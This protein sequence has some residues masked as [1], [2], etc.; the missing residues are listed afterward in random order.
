MVV[1]NSQLIYVFT[2]LK[3]VLYGP[4]I[5]AL[6]VT[7]TQFG[8]LL[9]FVGFITVFG[10]ATIG[11]LQDRFAIRKVLAVN[12]LMYGGWAMVMT[13]W[14][15]CPYILKC[16]F[17]I[18]FGFNGDA[19]Y[20]ATVLKSIRI[21][22]KEDKQATAFGMMESIRALIGF[23][24]SSAVVAIYTFLGSTLFGMRV[25]MGITSTFTIISGLTIWF[26]IPELK[27]TE[28]DRKLREEEKKAGKT[29]N[30]FGGFIKALKMPGVW[31]TGGAAMCVYA[32]FCAVNTYF[33]PYMQN[34]YLLPVALL[35]VFGIV[36]GYLTRI[37]AGGMAGIIADWKFKSS[38]HM[39]RGCYAVLAVLM[40]IVLLLPKNPKMVIPAMV[41]LLAISVF[42]GLVR[43]VYYAP[44]G[45]MGIPGEMSAAAMAVAS[46]IGYS[47]SFW[48]F[49]LYGALIDNFKPETAYTMIFGVLLAMSVAGVIFNTIL[50][51]KIVEHKKCM[52]LNNG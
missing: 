29:Q 24:M 5:E 2:N 10:G 41:C 18:S 22:A 20:W 33:L 9:G 15:G 19:M 50:G 44:I 4:F 28:E 46:C 52:K 27:P 43:S 47:P 1:S 11:W 30:A 49:P 37:L 45:E 14:P 17:F 48:A 25:V 38:A 32:S 34:V 42:C 8:V 31:M 35:G 7:N 16:L 26:F 12:S 3:S 6:G 40:I 51:K 13:L 36:N 39:M 23:I 21:M